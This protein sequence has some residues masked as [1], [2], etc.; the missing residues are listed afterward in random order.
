MFSI[1]RVNAI[2]TNFGYSRGRQT[3]GGWVAEWVEASEM[4]MRGWVV[5][6]GFCMSSSEVPQGKASASTREYPK[7]VLARVIFN[8]RQTY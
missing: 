4:L 7:L 8:A 2:K 5:L 6:V 3:D 1:A